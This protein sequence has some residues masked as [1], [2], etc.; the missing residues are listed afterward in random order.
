MGRKKIKT[1]SLKKNILISKKNMKVLFPAAV[2]FS[3]LS[4][5]TA[6]A[7]SAKQAKAE[8]TAKAEKSAKSSKSAERA[9]TLWWVLFNKPSE[10]AGNG[11]DM[12]DV[13]SN[14]G[15][16]SNYPQVSIVHAAGGIS[17]ERGFLRMTSTIYK[18][19]EPGLNLENNNRYVWGGPL[20]F[21]IGGSR[22]YCP[23]E[24]E[25]T[26][27][28]LVVRDHGPV[29]GNKLDQ[30][31]MFTDPSC[32]ARD[33]SNLCLDIGYVAFQ[34]DVLTKDIGHFPMF[35]PDCSTPQSEFGCSA[36]EEAI[37]LSAGMGNQVTFIRTGDAVQVVA[38][39]T[40][41]KI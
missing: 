7:K 34:G 31:T 17:D 6:G 4:L 19:K 37:Q 32:A 21:N 20:V 12:N 1:L 2:L 25:E 18:T 33:G 9:V 27:V 36:E 26:E 11:C 16:G 23:A 10:C 5:V 8:K 29:T 30:I 39:I 24:G 22:G 38:E 35:P 15:E 14:A 40:L 41:P 28:H 3:I 13:M